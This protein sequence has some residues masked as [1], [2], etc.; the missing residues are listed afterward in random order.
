MNMSPVHF[1]SSG[2]LTWGNG[3]QYNG[4]WVAG[5]MTGNAVFTYGGQGG[6]VYEGAFLNDKKV[7][8]CPFG[9]RN[10]WSLEMPPIF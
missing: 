9:V 2:V 5:R 6:D 8:G 7:C 3:N 10:T 1:C 4:D